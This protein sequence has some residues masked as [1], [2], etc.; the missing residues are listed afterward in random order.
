MDI[1]HLA[2][3][4]NQ[5]GAFYNAYPQTQAVDGIAT[6]IDK[7]W[8]PRMKQEIEKHAEAG[9]ELLQANVKAAIS[10]LMTARA[11]RKSA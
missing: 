4:A 6:H 8:D 10:K 5:I 1:H 2:Y 9:G 11:A 7:F 3:M